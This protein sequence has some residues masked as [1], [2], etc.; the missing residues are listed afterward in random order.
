M[1]ATMSRQAPIFTV[2]M[3]VDRRWHNLSEKAVQREAR[4]GARACILCI[5]QT[6]TPAVV[7]DRQK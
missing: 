1:A 2:M 6:S 4:R 3:R 5:T 7:Q